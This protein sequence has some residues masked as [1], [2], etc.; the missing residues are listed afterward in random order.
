MDKE[1]QEKFIIRMLINNINPRLIADDRNITIDEVKAIEEKNREYI[2]VEKTKKR[3]EHILSELGIN[4]LDEKVQN[5]Q[6]KIKKIRKKLIDKNKEEQ[7]RDNDRKRIIKTLINAGYAGKSI[8]Y[9]EFQYIYKM[10]GSQMSEI[11]FASD[12]LGVSSYY[13][14]KCRNEGLNIVILRGYRIKEQEDIEENENEYTTT[15]NKDININELHNS[16]KRFKKE[17]EVNMT[18]KI[19][20]SELAEER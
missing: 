12:V 1:L 10:L 19:E 20:S 5:K 8:N 11:S 15:D 14:I 9:E 6:K 4:T 2:E 7:N 3:E 18:H 13:L 17:D 16:L